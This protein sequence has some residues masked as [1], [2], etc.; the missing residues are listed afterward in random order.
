MPI[1]WGTTSAIRAALKKSRAPNEKFF[2]GLSAFT[3]S[4]L[5]GLNGLTDDELLKLGSSKQGV[6]TLGWVIEGALSDA[7]KLAVRLAAA[8]T[9]PKNAKHLYF[10]TANAALLGLLLGGTEEQ[11]KQ[12]IEVCL[13]HAKKEAGIFVNAALAGAA[14]GDADLALK[15]LKQA[16]SKSKGWKRAFTDA[17]FKP[18]SKD[19]RYLA[20]K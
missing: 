1:A 9:S 13:P 6:L 7:P 14:S 5:K 15:L 2:E 12:A 16:K 10:R 18:F 11:L 19:P 17:R 3:A 20:L 8:I 4:H